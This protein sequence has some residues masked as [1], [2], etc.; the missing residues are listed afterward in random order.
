MPSGTCSRRMGFAD[1]IRL[2]ASLTVLGARLPEGLLRTRSANAETGLR[3]PSTCVERSARQKR[4]ARLGY[5]MAMVRSGIP[6][7]HAG[8]ANLVVALAR[9]FCVAA[10][11]NPFAG[12]FVKCAREAVKPVW[13]LR[14]RIVW[15]VEPDG[16]GGGLPGSVSRQPLL[17]AS[18]RRRVS[19]DSWKVVFTGARAWTNSICSPSGPLQ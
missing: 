13:S 3:T 10:H 7:R 1:T 12:L 18:M 6:S 11:L 19:M 14:A 15:P 5:G 9:P 4:A 8:A 2:L 17:P 16:S